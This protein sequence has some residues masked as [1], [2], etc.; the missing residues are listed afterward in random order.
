MLAA[1]RRILAQ[2]A[3]AKSKAK[4]AAADAENAALWSQYS[5]LRD[6]AIDRFRG[7]RERGCRASR[8]L[9]YF[10]EGNEQFRV[11]KC[12]PPYIHPASLRKWLNKA[13]RRVKSLPLS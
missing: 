1:E 12:P 13:I 5:D 7:I 8:E 6:A 3:E 10:A 2:I 4:R 9:W 11:F